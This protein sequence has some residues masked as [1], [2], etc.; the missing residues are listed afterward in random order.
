MAP[1]GTTV[2]AAELVAA[3]IGEKPRLHIVGADPDKTV[4]LLRD[5]LSRTETL[6]DR[7]VPVRLA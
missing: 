3:A 2:S 7:G 6:F 5:V 1:D 4:A